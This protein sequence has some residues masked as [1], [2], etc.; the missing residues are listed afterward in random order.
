MVCAY[1][2][3]WL[4]ATL[5]YFYVILFFFLIVLQLWRFFGPSDDGVVIEHGIRE[6]ILRDKLSQY[7]M[8][9]GVT[10]AEILPSLGEHDAVYGLETEKRR[11][12]LKQLVDGF[13]R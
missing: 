4:A 2:L 9:F 12:V 8:L 3:W 1:G 10:R 13:Y 7:P 5:L 11:E 6:N